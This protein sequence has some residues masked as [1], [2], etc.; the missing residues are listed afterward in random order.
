[1]KSLSVKCTVIDCKNGMYG[2][3][4]E[5]IYASKKEYKYLTCDRERI[6]SLADKI[7]RLEVSPLHIEDII[8]DFL[9]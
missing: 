8:D 6:N 7:N 5:S 3:S 2:V 4:V 1:M 9:E